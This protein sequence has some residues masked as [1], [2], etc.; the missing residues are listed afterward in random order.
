MEHVGPLRHPLAAIPTTIAPPSTCVAKIATIKCHAC[1]CALAFSTEK[2]NRQCLLLWRHHM[3]AGIHRLYS[4]LRNP[5]SVGSER[6]AR[7]LFVNHGMLSLL[8]TCFAAISDQRSPFLCLRATIGSTPSIRAI[9]SK[10]HT[11]LCNR[12]HRHV[13]VRLCSESRC[14]EVLPVCAR[15]STFTTAIF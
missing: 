1:A 4:K 6:I 2:F 7:L 8:G 10:R 14:D 9:T 11:V 12:L 3:V 5:H 13:S 15:R